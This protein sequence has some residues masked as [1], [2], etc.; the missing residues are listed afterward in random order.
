MRYNNCHKWYKVC[1][2]EDIKMLEETYISTFN[3]LRDAFTKTKEPQIVYISYHEDFKENDWID[4]AEC[5]LLSE[6]K[7]ETISFWKK[8]GFDIEFKKSE[9]C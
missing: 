8:F 7:K 5:Y 6:M 9:E 2:F 4:D 3:N 1:S